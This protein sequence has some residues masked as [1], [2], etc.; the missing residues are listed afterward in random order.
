MLSEFVVML[1]VDIFL[2]NVTATVV[3][4]ETPVEL[5]IGLTE[6]TV[7]RFSDS[8]SDSVVNPLVV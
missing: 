3:E 8:S 7:G 4:T 6:E 5:S 2:L 1:L